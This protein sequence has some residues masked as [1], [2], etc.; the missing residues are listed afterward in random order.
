M[1]ARSAESHQSIGLRVVQIKDGD[2]GNLGNR[3]RF[4]VTDNSNIHRNQAVWALTTLSNCGQV[5]SSKWLTKGTQNIFANRKTA[6][7]PL[8]LSGRTS[9]SILC[10][11]VL[12][13]H[14][15]GNESHFEYVKVTVDWTAPNIT[16]QVT[17]NTAGVPTV[18]TTFDDVEKAWWAKNLASDWCRFGSTSRSGIFGDG[19]GS[20]PGNWRYKANSSATT[21]TEINWNPI[22]LTSGAGSVSGLLATDTSLCV[23][24]DDSMGN[25]SVNYLNIASERVGLTVTQTGN[26]LSYSSTDRLVYAGPTTTEVDCTS[27]EP[28]IAPGWF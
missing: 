28:G 21:H 22:T 18:N 27:V 11:G 12:H 13:R 8:D 3:F 1:V 17:R 25:K 2:D 5:P 4:S 24:A 26:D 20:L 16:W 7:V 19:G 10:A 6:T 14:P 23:L 15:S 9:N